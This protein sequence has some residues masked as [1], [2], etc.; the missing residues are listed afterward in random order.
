[1][2][3]AGTGVSYFILYSTKM[4]SLLAIKWSNVFRM[5]A[6]V[7]ILL[8]AQIVAFVAKQRQAFYCKCFSQCIISS[9]AE[10]RVHHAS[11][12]SRTCFYLPPIK[13][14]GNCLSTNCNAQVWP[15]FH[16][17]F[18]LACLPYAH[19]IHKINNIFSVLVLW[20]TSFISCLII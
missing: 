12:G 13:C 20:K 9:R 6:L 2:A 16:P 19:C 8:R 14:I 15:K 11:M 1:M 10:R 5:M 7:N 18:V 3:N 4:F 17:L